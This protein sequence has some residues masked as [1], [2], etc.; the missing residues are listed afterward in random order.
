MRRRGGGHGKRAHRDSGGTGY[1]F[2]TSTVRSGARALQLL[3]AGAI[4]ST[5]TGTA[6][7]TSLRRVARV[8]VYFATLPDKEI[9]IFGHAYTNGPRV[10]FNQSDSKLY[11]GVGNS[12]GATL[13]ATGASVTT[14][15]WYRIDYHGLIVSAGSDTCDVMVDGV[16]LGTATATGSTSTFIFGMRFGDSTQAWTGDLFFDDLIV[17]E[18]AGDYPLGAGYVNAL[19][20][21]E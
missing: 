8:Y 4:V 17:S 2:S 16:A 9:P 14:G 12:P 18:T 5:E 3:A 20:A 11:A 7:F 10:V 15:Q 6:L 13:G 21:D 1:S 19:R